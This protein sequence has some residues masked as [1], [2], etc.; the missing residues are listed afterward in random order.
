[1]YLLKNY[2]LSLLCILLLSEYIGLFKAQD[3][4]SFNIYV[5]NQKI[6]SPQNGSKEY[7][8]EQLTDVLNAINA[9]PTSLAQVN[10]YIAPSSDSYKLANSSY[11]T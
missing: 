2:W 11:G 9:L 6:T 7:P 3:S 1:M 10:V 8:F 5:N 4:S